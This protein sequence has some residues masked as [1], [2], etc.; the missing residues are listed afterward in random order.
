MWLITPT[1]PFGEQEIKAIN[2]W[3]FRGG[4]LVVVTDHTDLFGHASALNP[5]L[6]RL[7]ITV[8]KDVILD[9]TGEGGTYY[10]YGGI[11]QGLSAN[12]VEGAGE[13][14]LFQPGYS[15][16]TDYS[17]KSFF[18]DN[19]ISDEERF[20]IYSI[21]LR[22]PYGIG[23]VIV[24]GDSTMWANFAMARPS[25]QR[26]LNNTL[27]GGG[28][29]SCYAFA[30]FAC[31]SI[32]LIHLSIKNGAKILLLGIEA[33]AFLFFCFSVTK[34]KQLCLNDLATTDVEGDWSL[35]EGNDAHLLTLFSSAYITSPRFPIW[36]GCSDSSRTV[37]IGDNLVKVP[38]SH[39]VSD[40][41]GTPEA[42][43]EINCQNPAKGME[44]I[45]SRYIADSGYASFWFDDGVGVLREFAYKLFWE[46]AV[47][48]RGNNGGLSLGKTSKIRM[49][50]KI[51]N[52][53]PFETTACVT[54]I[55]EESDWVILG[56]WI[57]GKVVSEDTILI[58]SPWQLPL[59][60]IPDFYCKLEHKE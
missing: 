29:F 8:N 11:H 45:I 4:R 22:V 27:Q 1:K 14:W 25:S 42:I 3:V 48:K 15:E 9:K 36:K 23:G 51:R 32:I 24:F 18:S 47:N 34:S 56:N 57:L 5:L 54:P 13:T 44:E 17:K 59:R 53:D 20:D 21:G 35:V 52:N 50:I 19:Q 43:Q 46:Q 31:L 2:D 55:N 58:R 39:P 49:K 28:F 38:H 6:K 60:N 26:L 16:R 10:S 41:D 12:S 37:R 33:S 30:F 40:S 7:G